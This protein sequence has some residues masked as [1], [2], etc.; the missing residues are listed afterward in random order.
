[1]KLERPIPMTKEFYVDFPGFKVDWEHRFESG[2]PHYLRNGDWLH[3][4]RTEN[5]ASPLRR[6]NS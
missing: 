2:S 4:R 3:F 1:M 5:G 6:G